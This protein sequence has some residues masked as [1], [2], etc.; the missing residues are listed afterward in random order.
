MF[1]FLLICEQG[2]KFHCHSV[3]TSKDNYCKLKL[4]NKAKYRVQI[5]ALLSQARSH[6]CM[7]ALR[8]CFYFN[9]DKTIQV[10]A[11]EEGMLKAIY[12]QDLT[13]KQK[14]NSFRK[15]LLV[16]ATYELNNLRLPVFLQLVIDGNGKSYTVAVLLLHQ[17]MVK[18]W[19][20]LLRYSN[21]IILLGKKTRTIYILTDKDFTE[22]SVYFGQFS[23]ANLQ[24]CLFHVLK[25]MRHETHCEKMNICLEQKSVFLDSTKIAYSNNEMNIQRIMSSCQIP[26]FSQ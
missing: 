11:D 15:L 22:R 17:K 2:I 20:H 6:L 5:Y 24:L 18:G 16:D 14:F 1:A 10:I 9:L 21:S 23:N 7:L 19:H 12:Y 13:M 4:K 8:K 26:A 3:C 25:S